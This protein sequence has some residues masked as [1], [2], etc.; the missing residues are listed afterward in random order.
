LGLAGFYRKFVKHFAILAR[1]LTNLLKK[2]ALFIWTVEHQSA[3]A[4]LQQA[5]CSAPVLGIPDFSKPFAIETDACQHGV[6]AVLMQ[7]GHPLAYVS[8][9]LGIKTQGLS[10][11]EKEYLAILV[12][13]EKWR[14]YLQLAEF[15]IHTDQQALVHLNDQRLHTVWQQ[16]VF[17]KLLGLRYKVV[18]KKGG[19]NGV[20]DALSRRQHPPSDCFA[21]SVATPT[22]CYELQNGYHADPQ[23]TKLLT[24]LA[25][26]PTAVPHFTL[27]D[28]LLR[29]KNR[30]WIGNNT[31]L[32]RQLIEQMH[33]SPIGGHSGIPATVKR[34]QSLFAWPQL[35]KQV[36][37]FVKSCPTCQ[38]AKPERV[39]YP[40]LLRPL[41]TPT[42][43]WQVISLDFVEGLPLSHGYDCI[44]VVVDLFS[45]YSNY[46]P[47]KHPFTALTV[48]KLFMVHIYRL[49]G[50]PTAIV[51]DRNKIF[52]SHLWRE[53]FRL[54][55][56]ELRMSSAYHP[57]S[58]GQTERV[59]QC[60]ET[61][62]RCFAN[63]AP[64]KWFDFLHL[65]EYWYNTTWH[66]SLQQSPFQV[67]YG[68]SPRQLGI[69]SSAACSVTSLAE[70]MQQKAAMQSLI[71]QHL[72]R[73]RNR[74]KLQADKKR[75]ERSFPLGAWVYVK[76]QPYVQTSLAPRANQKLAYR[77]F[78]PYKIEEK[79]GSVAYKLQL[80]PESTIHPV[81]H[82]SQ[83]KGVIPTTHSASPLPVAFDGLQV[84]ERIL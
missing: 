80:P 46:V 21:L 10:T 77:F 12:A 45:K 39:K 52:T 11:Y 65:A 79:I 32:Q 16:K 66:S 43:A 13:V 31:N 48:A 22:W 60:M 81:F 49:H 14:S 61:F 67:L 40:G 82:V 53:L 44:L 29:F 25:A 37:A 70:W 3:F 24:T 69:D 64:N 78:G 23:A 62:L 58:D 54:A 59:N 20:A 51:S 72:A 4:A 73:A 56:V 9:P 15:E 75:T 30:L 26:N 71:Q 41:E 83:L 84:P 38:Q 34:L 47:L 1:P 28:G 55:G 42:S 63:A 36:A 5:L 33:N 8:K 7:A 18:Y 68:Q 2:H 57:Q 76:L 6:G 17:T 27:V 35:K 19:D 50:L 74:M